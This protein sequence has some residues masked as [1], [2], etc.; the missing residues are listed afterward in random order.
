[1]TGANPRGLIEPGIVN[2]RY[3]GGKSV[4]QHFILLLAGR[5]LGPEQFS[6][7]ALEVERTLCVW[8]VTNTLTKEYERLIIEWAGRLRS[9][10]SGKA[11]DQFVEDT[12]R[13][14]RR[15]RSVDFHSAM[16]SAKVTDMRRFRAR[17]L[18]AKLTQ[19]I[20]VQAYGVNGGQAS[21]AHYMDGRNDLEHI[22]PENPSVGALAEFDELT[23]DPLIIQRLGNVVLLE[24]SVNR[25][26]Q[27]DAYSAKAKVYPS[28]QFLL[29][30]CQ[31]EHLPVGTND[32]ITRATRRIPKF[33]RWNR[34]SIEDRQHY[35]ATL[36]K[37]VW[38]TA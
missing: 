37:E 19:H 27:N 26:I 5:H 17:Y 33:G 34:K 6:R 23:P 29:T 4:R 30:R 35:L 28:S 21:L 25:S 7:L 15:A 36:S 1:V 12:F 22:L 20:D 10:T 24:D 32:R 2:T 11:F 14:T 18:V 38:E 9:L 16:R 13:A 31:A 8:L 3:L